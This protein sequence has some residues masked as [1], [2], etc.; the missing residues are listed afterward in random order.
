M[1][2]KFTKEHEWVLLEG[3]EV[4]I[5]IT[6]YAQKQ[7]GDIVYISLTR[8]IGEQ[9]ETKEEVAE[10][11]SVKSVSQIYAPV[12][13]E[14]TAFNEILED[15]SQTASVN[16]DPYGKGWIFKMKL[17]D[18]AQLDTLMDEKAY[19]EYVDSL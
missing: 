6:D 1:G 5:G 4:T 18:P 19:Q 3:E 2:K 8:D 11:E 9:V 14:L 13:G 12:S 16:E 17:S 10:I 7:L 15:E